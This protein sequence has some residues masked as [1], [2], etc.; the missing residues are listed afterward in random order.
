[1]GQGKPTYLLGATYKDSVKETQAPTCKVQP[2]FSGWNEAMRIGQNLVK[3][4]L[5]TEIEGQ[6]SRQT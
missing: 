1:M 4:A 2:R 6:N 3:A 5:Q